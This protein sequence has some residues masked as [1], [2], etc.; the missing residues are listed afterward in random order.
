MGPTEETKKSDKDS[1]DVGY[2][3]CEELMSFYPIKGYHYKFVKHISE[4]TIWNVLIRRYPLCKR[5]RVNKKVCSSHRIE[6][7]GGVILLINDNDDNDIHIMLTIENKSQYSNGNAIERINKN[8]NIIKE[9]FKDY[10][11]LP[12]IIFETG[13]LGN[14]YLQS[15][16]RQGFCTDPSMRSIYK[17]DGVLVFVKEDGFTYDEKYDITMELAKEIHSYYNNILT[18]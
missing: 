15:K 3:I 13:T 17:D 9:F 11:I 8:Y 7:D 2:N 18:I 10:S 1:F 12:Y 5:Y 14:D 16:I 6:P 4:S